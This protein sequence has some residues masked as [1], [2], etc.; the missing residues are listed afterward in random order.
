M[1]YPAASSAKFYKTATQL[2]GRS[3]TSSIPKPEA[4]RIIRPSQH[5]ELSNSLINAVVALANETARAGYGAL[6][7]CSSR[8]GC[9]KDALLISQ[10]LPQ[11][12]ECSIDMMNKRS[13]LLNDLRSTSSGLDHILEQTVP[14]GVAFHRKSRSGLTE[15]CFLSLAD[16][17]L[18][19]EERDLVASAYDT[20][21]LKVIV[22]TC[23]LA[24][25]INLPARRV[26]LHGARMGADLVGPSML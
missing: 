11:F 23:S 18:T 17:G 24:A 13:E 21:A 26:I 12:E 1:V 14:R 4:K 8:A 6:V 7:F 10:V 19:I 2:T 20:G 16:A 5:K 3:Q 25:G 9:E 22:A 15:I